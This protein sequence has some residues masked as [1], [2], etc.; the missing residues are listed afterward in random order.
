V[1]ENCC[2]AGWIQM[3]SPQKRLKGL[4]FTKTTKHANVHAQTTKKGREG[5]SKALQEM[6]Q[7]YQVTGR[8]RM[9]QGILG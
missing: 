4:R 1:L 6:M 3:L 7:R 5:N 9:H 2:L 8:V